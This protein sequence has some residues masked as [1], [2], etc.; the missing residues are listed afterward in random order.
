MVNLKKNTIETRHFLI[1][2]YGNK[3]YRLRLEV[4]INN[5]SSQER[6]KNVYRRVCSDYINQNIAIRELETGK[7]YL[8][9]AQHDEV[10]NVQKIICDDFS[11]F[12]LKN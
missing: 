8:F 12:E 10:G 3:W 7:T 2:P 4:E 11:Q 6:C 1:M 5:T 9:N